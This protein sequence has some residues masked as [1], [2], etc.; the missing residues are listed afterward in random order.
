MNVVVRQE[1][2]KMDDKLFKRVVMILLVA[3]M[4]SSMA[5]IGYTAHLHSQCSILNYIANERD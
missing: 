5:L 4:I 3:G 2:K 1:E